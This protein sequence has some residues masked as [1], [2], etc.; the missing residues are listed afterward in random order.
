MDSVWRRH[1]STAREV[2]DDVGAERDWAYTT[3]KTVLDRLVAKGVLASEKEGAVLR[4]RPRLSRARARAGA[5]RH[6]VERAFGGTAAPLMHQLLDTER[7]SAEERKELQRR[8]DEL[9]TEP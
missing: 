1:R 7:L 2:H 4:Y 5:L 6:L 8:L 3:V 9:E